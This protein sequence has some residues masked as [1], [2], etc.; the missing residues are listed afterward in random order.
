[1]N[2]QARVDAIKR[3]ITE[4]QES[5][6]RYD[7][8]VAEVYERMLDDCAESIHR[9]DGVRVSRIDVADAIRSTPQLRE[10]P[11]LRR[12]H[13]YVD[14]TIAMEG[15]YVP[16]LTEEQRRAESIN[17][18]ATRVLDKISSELKR[19]LSDG[20]YKQFSNPIDNEYMAAVPVQ[21]TVAAARAVEREVAL[22][23]QINFSMQRRHRPYLTSITR[24]NIRQPMRR[25]PKQVFCTMFYFHFLENPDL[26]AAPPRDL[27]RVEPVGSPRPSP[28]GID[29]V[30]LLERKRE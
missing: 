7:C 8:T 2:R 28:D 20:S 29:A 4:T 11:M 12:E 9:H 10:H 15:G 6:T 19:M 16:A 24:Y 25:E 18:E 13:A 30:P 23:Y 21:Y 5:G 27:V 1:M 14:S 26:V 3:F 22:F 17:Q